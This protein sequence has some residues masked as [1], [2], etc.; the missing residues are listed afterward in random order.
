[1]ASTL[2]TK[3]RGSPP[4]RLLIHLLT[5]VVVGAALAVGGPPAGAS[6]AAT[7][8]EPRSSRSSPTSWR[9]RARRRSGSASSRPTSTAAAQTQDWTK[10]GQAVYDALRKA[11][12]SRQKETVALLKSEDVR[13][14]S[15]WATNAIR[16]EAGDSG[17]AAEIAADKAVTGIYPAMSYELEKPRKGEELK[18]VD[19][20]EWGIANINADDVWDQ[21]GV[22][23]EGIV[24]RQHRQRR[25]VR[26]PGAGRAV[27]GQ[28]R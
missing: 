20:V 8:P 22:T 17:L 1:M 9:R 14:Q 24:D 25:A 23:G 18:E 28:Q 7:G 5:L 27:P 3:G 11:A 12:A 13:Y 16:V 19:A 21:Y 2:F 26:P 4:R 10:R 6:P 15:F